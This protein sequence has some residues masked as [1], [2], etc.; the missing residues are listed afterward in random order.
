MREDL[1]N[2]DIASGKCINASVPQNISFGEQ[3]GVL[4]HNSALPVGSLGRM[5]YAAAFAGT[6]V[7]LALSLL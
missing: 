2:L 3:G 7:A 6:L 4:G 1:V 5:Q